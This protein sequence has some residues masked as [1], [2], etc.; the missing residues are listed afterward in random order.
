M[1]V[2]IESCDRD[3][4]VTELVEKYEPV[5]RSEAVATIKR[6]VGGDT[7]LADLWC[8]SLLVEEAC[9]EAMARLLHAAQR[10][11]AGSRKHEGVGFG[12]YARR[13]VRNHLTQWGQKEFRR[14]GRFPLMSQLDEQARQGMKGG[15]SLGRKGNSGPRGDRYSGFEQSLRQVAAPDEGYG[16]QAAREAL[17]LLRD[18]V[19]K[20][21][22]QAARVLDRFMT[23]EGELT[24][25]TKVA[26]QGKPNSKGRRY[27][28]KQKGFYNSLRRIAGLSMP[29]DQL[30]YRRAMEVIKAAARKLSL[31]SG[32]FA[33]AVALALGGEAEGAA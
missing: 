7:R 8:R 27:V 26:C 32:E 2:E 17:A 13:V 9:C 4:S 30:A 10:Y 25:A 23:P 20:S 24:L 31:A 5:A 6:M 28:P 33:E 1:S 21:S 11:H 3:L 16:R 19:A 18:A 14:A 15:H 22:P 12:P 29:Q